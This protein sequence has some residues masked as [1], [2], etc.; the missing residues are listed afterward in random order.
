MHARGW[1]ARV[2]G[3]IG[4]AHLTWSTGVYSSASRG[5]L[6]RAIRTK[7]IPPRYEPVGCAT[8]E[9]VSWVRTN[10][11]WAWLGCKSSDCSNR[12]GR[13]RST[14]LGRLAWMMSNGVR[15]TCTSQMRRSMFASS[16]RSTCARKEGIPLRRGS[17]LGLLLCGVLREGN[18][19]REGHVDLII[20]T[21]HPSK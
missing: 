5:W 14:H 4:W 2:D 12:L 11:D 9:S 8:I 19:V 1:R 6:C 16:K 10:R 7:A 18:N 20:I 17:R 13:Q 15:V 21:V 3:R